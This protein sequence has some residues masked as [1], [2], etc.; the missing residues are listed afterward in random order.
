MGHKKINIWNLWEIFCRHAKKN[1]IYHR[2]KFQ[3]FLG[4]QA[5]KLF[6]N[7]DST[8]G[9]SRLV[10]FHTT[11]HRVSPMRSF[12]LRELHDNQVHEIIGMSMS[13]P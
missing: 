13:I 8:M 7:P 3:N 11:S 4:S 9:L 1:T 5:R 12:G 6:A 10:T 2:K